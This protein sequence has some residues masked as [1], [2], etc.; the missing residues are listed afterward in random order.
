MKKIASN[1]AK[2]IRQFWSDV[3]KVFEAQNKR[4]GSKETR[5]KLH[6]MHLNFIVDKADKYTERL[7][8]ELGKTLNTTEESVSIEVDK[9]F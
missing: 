3:E 7:T 2:Q 4:F 9:E 8:Q 6:D 5:K 1:I